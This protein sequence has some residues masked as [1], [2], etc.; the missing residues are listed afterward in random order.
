MIKKGQKDVRVV[1]AARLKMARESAGYI[2][3]EDF[4][5]K[6]GFELGYYQRHENAE[7]AMLTSEIIQY[8]AALK[9]SVCFLMLGEEEID[10]KKL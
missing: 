9:I 7:H 5:E 10:L 3:A 8:C 1:I 4:C 2:S 6:H